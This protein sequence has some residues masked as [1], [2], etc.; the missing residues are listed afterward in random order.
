MVDCVCVWLYSTLG[1]EQ[2]SSATV[3]LGRM[4]NCISCTMFVQSVKY[5]Y[6]VHWYK[7]VYTCTCI[8]T[9]MYMHMEYLHMYIYMY[10][11]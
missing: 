8:Y 3:M 5:T 9:Y 10:Y 7:Y 6:I 11:V 2:L 4:S 1:C